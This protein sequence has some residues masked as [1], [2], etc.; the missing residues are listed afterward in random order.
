MHNTEVISVRGRNSHRKAAKIILVLLLLLFSVEYI[1]EGNLSVYRLGIFPLALLGCLFVSPSPKYSNFGHSVTIF[2]IYLIIYSLCLLIHNDNYLFPIFTIP[3]A[4]FL[5]AIW[6]SREPFDIDYAKIFS[7]Y[8]VPHIFALVSGRANFAFGRFAG[9]HYDPNFCA[10]FITIATI[11]SFFLIIRERQSFAK[12]MFFCILLV[13]DI[14]LLLLTGSRGGIMSLL[15][16]GLI[17]FF[18][19]HAKFRLKIIVGLALISIGLSIFAYIQSLPDFVSPE[20]SIIDSF[21]VRLKPDTVEEGGGR[22]EVWEGVWN[23]IFSSGDWITPYGRL[24]A[25]QGFMNQYTHNS[26][27]DFLVENG[28]ILGIIIVVSYLIALFKSFIRLKKNK[29][30]KN[31]I[32]YLWCCYAVS[33]EMFFISAVSQKIFWIFFFFVFAKSQIIRLGKM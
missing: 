29:I 12:R 23:R 31:E 1:G 11:S 28:I 19:S 21:L 16:V 32:P 22:T 2:S 33:F 5:F 17:M 15:A 30:N 8:S 24:N 20:D 26:Y 18:S 7:F 13:V 27:L 25:M 6:F 10:I 3:L 14:I 4:Y 9:L